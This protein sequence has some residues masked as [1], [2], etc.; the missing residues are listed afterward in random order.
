G[1]VT[2]FTVGIPHFSQLSGITTG[3]DGNLWFTNTN[4]V[5]IGR[6]TP[7]GLVTEFSTGITGG[8]L[9]G[10]AAGPD[11]ALWFAEFFG[12]KIG[13]ITTAGVITEFPVC[14][15]TPTPGAYGIT[16]GPDGNLWFTEAAAP[17][18]IPPPIGRITPAGIVTEFSTPTLP[19][20]GSVPTGITAGPD[21]NLWFAE[22]SGNRIGRITPLGV[23]TEFATGITAGAAPFGITA[24]PDGNL[25]F[26]EL[27]GNRIGRITTGL[28]A[29]GASFFALAPCRVL[30]TRNPPASLGGPP[31]QPAGSPDRLFNVASTC[32]ILTN[33]TAIS[34][35]VTVTNTGG[36][37]YLSLY[38]GDGARTG[39]YSIS[40]LAGQTRANNALVQLALDLSGSIRVQNTA[41]GNVDF[42]LDVN[43]FFR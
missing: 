9:R 19:T 21:G 29:P 32:G 43:G 13:R 31:L 17:L 38:R 15:T 12:A 2:E 10:I 6:I 35:N 20:N 1:V 18:S 34:A 4:Y 27:T 23:I 36:G 22:Q 30:D 5:R 41:P 11:G 26:T 42:I 39:T 14:C 8:G 7:L 3:P 25:W 33:A 24:G 28:T 16:A 40:F 37:G